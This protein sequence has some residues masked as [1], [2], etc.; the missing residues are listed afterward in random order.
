L[1]RTQPHPQRL[2]YR[3]Q[4]HAA[5][6]GSPSPK[7]RWTDAQKLAG[8]ILAIDPSREDLRRQSK[9]AAVKM[10]YDDGQQL[11]KQEFGIDPSAQ[12]RKLFKELMK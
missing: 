9:P 4:L 5:V 10:G 8:E 7:K 6:N 1:R 2:Y 12:T 11:L 3:E